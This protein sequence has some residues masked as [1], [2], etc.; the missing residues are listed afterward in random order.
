MIGFILNL[1]YTILGLVTGLLSVPI[2]VTFREKPY[3]FILKVKR[4]WLP[5]KNLRAITIGHVILLGPKLQE[6]DL[7]HE[8]VHVEQFER[9]PLI[10]P[11]LYW[12]ELYNKGYRG[13]TYE[14]EAYQKAGNLYEK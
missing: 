6:K 3:A 5:I 10:F 2:S 8:L 7:E 4:L 12:H 14:D 11:I 13:N 9:Q 1:P